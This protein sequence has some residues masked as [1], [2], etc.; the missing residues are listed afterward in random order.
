MIIIKITILILITIVP[1]FFKGGFTMKLS[2]E[3]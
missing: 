3:D 2:P 1:I